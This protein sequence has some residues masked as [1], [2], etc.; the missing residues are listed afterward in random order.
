MKGVT[1][2]ILLVSSVLCKSCSCSSGNSITSTSNDHASSTTVSF[3][4]LSN[5][6]VL[7]ISDYNQFLSSLATQNSLSNISNLVASASLYKTLS[8]DP[9]IRTIVGPCKSDMVLPSGVIFPSNDLCTTYQPITAT[10]TANCSSRS[11]SRSSIC[12]PTTTMT[13]PFDLPSGVAPKCDV[14]VT[15]LC[16]PTTTITIPS[17]LPSGFSTP[18]FVKIVTASST[19][20]LCIPS[21]TITIP[22]SLPTGISIPC[23]LSVIIKSSSS[24]SSSVCTPRTTITIPHGLPDAIS[25]PC[26]LRVVVAPPSSSSSAT[27]ST[28]T[29]QVPVSTAI[30]TFNVPTLSTMVTPVVIPVIRTTNHAVTPILACVMPTPKSSANSNCDMSAML[31]KISAMKSDKIEVKPKKTKKSLKRKSKRGK[32]GGKKDDKK[33]TKKSSKGDKKKKKSKGKDSDDDS[34]SKKLVSKRKSDRKVKSKGKYSD[35]DSKSKRLVSKRK[36]DH[37]VKKERGRRNR[38]SDRMNKIPD[39]NGLKYDKLNHQVNIPKHPPGRQPLIYTTTALCPGKVGA[40]RG[41]GIGGDLNGRSKS[42]NLIS[43]PITPKTLI[44]IKSLPAST[45]T[46]ITTATATEVLAFANFRTRTVTSYE[47]EPVTLT[48]TQ[49]NAYEILKTKIKKFFVTKTEVATKKVTQRFTAIEP[50]SIYITSEIKVKV[51][52]IQV[53]SHNKYHT[54]TIKEPAFVT[55]TS[56]LPAEVQVSLSAVVEKVTVTETRTKDPIEVIKSVTVV[57]F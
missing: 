22:M 54:V 52:T 26:D 25:T 47:V 29:S 51:P 4:P 41:K 45:A 56:T 2:A 10:T 23:G 39:G 9:G 49:I 32:K 21:T 34:K 24:S 5:D 1:L 35:G 16:T 17:Q 13:L 30:R 42:G 46:V 3:K 44:I 27:T 53:V 14:S 18:C 19:S 7:T 15:K 11:S 12:T 40:R 38:Q 6:H 31:S 50:T 55:V 36:S 20:T 28:S 43:S 8:G 48:A 33:G 37:K 57:E